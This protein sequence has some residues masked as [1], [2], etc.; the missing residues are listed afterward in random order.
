[1]K[2]KEYYKELELKKVENI[3][4]NMRLYLR[5][6]NVLLDNCLHRKS[7]KFIEKLKFY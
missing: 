2:E 6:R 1:M 3:Y 4:M 7:V 5:V